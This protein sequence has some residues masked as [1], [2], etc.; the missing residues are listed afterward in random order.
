MEVSERKVIP[1]IEDRIR[2]LWLKDSDF[3][4]SKK[5]KMMKEKDEIS[6]EIESV[7]H[8]V[9]DLKNLRDNL[10]DNFRNPKK[11]KRKRFILLPPPRH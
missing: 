6:S 3:Y 4:S 8:Q 1:G 5:A 9:A 11:T 2:D 7:L 10:I